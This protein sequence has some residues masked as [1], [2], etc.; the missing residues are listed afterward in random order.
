MIQAI[1]SCK[2]YKASPR[3]EKIQAAMNDPVNL[4]LVTQLNSYLDPEYRQTKSM[5]NKDSEPEESYVVDI[6][7]VDA[8][9]TLSLSGASYSFDH[10]SG[11]DFG[12]VDMDPE[13]TEATH[14]E[15]AGLADD[16][17][18]VV[19]NVSSEVDADVS[20]EVEEVTSAE[21][22]ETAIISHEDVEEIKATLNTNSDTHG[23]NRALIKDTELWIYY[24]DEVN[25]NNVMGPVIESLNSGKYKC[26]EFNRLARSTN[27]I[28]FQI[29][30]V[31]QEDNNGR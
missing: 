24:E 17:S 6:D 13:V 30:N 26:L 5:D 29:L 1:Y 31:A 18:E 25:L 14:S 27:A 11:S 2:L 3:K 19:D 28:V 12:S 23:V 9:D 20:S 22:L 4:E 21:E 8:D 16:V 15:P 10:S 7:P